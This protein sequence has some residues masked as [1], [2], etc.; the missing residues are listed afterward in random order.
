MRVVYSLIPTIAPENFIVPATKAE[1][2]RLAEAYK[3]TVW[4][5]CNPHFILVSLQPLF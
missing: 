4:E 3:D 2:K 5:C 1:H